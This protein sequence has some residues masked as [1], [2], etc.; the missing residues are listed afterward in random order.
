MLIVCIFFYLHIY[1]SK[2]LNPLYIYLIGDYLLLYGEILLLYGEI[3]LLY[4]EILLLKNKWLYLGFLN[5]NFKVE[6]IMKHDIV[7]KG[8][9]LTSI[10]S[11][12]KSKNSW[13]I[14]EIKVVLLLFK[15]LSNYKIYLP[16]IIELDSFEYDFKGHRQVNY[17]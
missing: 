10:F 12:I 5:G 15:E 13:S 16:N 4:G 11:N 14:N 6:I 3:L 17:P 9:Y 1:I 7:E 8:F 2:E